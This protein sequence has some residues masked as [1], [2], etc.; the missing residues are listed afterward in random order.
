MIEEGDE[1][2][3]PP[4]A[5]PHWPAT[6]Q[7]LV[8][9]AGAYADAPSPDTAT[10]LRLLAQARLTAK[11]ATAVEEWLLMLS[12][13]RGATLEDLAEITGASRKYVRGPDKRL[14]RLAAQYGTPAARLSALRE[15]VSG[16]PN[17]ACDD[18][19]SH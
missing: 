6:P 14:Q 2:G 18:G 9:W 7:D 15:R 11:T 1:R 8:G 12:R 10:L 13:E 19:G 5:P 4:A 3:A 16:D 17:S